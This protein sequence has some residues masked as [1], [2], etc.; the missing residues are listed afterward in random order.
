M[1]YQ[2]TWCPGYSGAVFCARWVWWMIQTGSELNKNFTLHDRFTMLPWLTTESLSKPFKFNVFRQTVTCFDTYAV[3]FSV[4]P[5][6][7]RQFII[8]KASQSR[9]DLFRMI[10]LHTKRPRTKFWPPT[11]MLRTHMAVFTIPTPTPK[12][13]TH[14][15]QACVLLQAMSGNVHNGR[16]LG[17]WRRR[18]IPDS[19]QVCLP[20]AS[21]SR[22]LSEH[23]FHLF[24]LHLNWLGSCW[25]FELTG[26]SAYE[27]QISEDQEGAI[28][29]SPA[30]TNTS[31]LIYIKSK[32]VMEG[33]F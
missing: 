2:K 16:R 13:H 4:F 14:T 9:C 3:I 11:T 31:M 25:S 15:H 33:M 29:Q 24:Q 8:S 17:S 6:V 19:L 30:K 21:T 1:K 5:A 28:V 20:V 7:L 10:A 23:K 12:A 18:C 22:N 26:N 27:S 32:R